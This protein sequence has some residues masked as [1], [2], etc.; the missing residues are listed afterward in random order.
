VA[1]S[2]QTAVVDVLVAKTLQAVESCGA[3]QVVL[4]G[5]VAANSKLQS[6]LG[7]ACSSRGIPLYF[8]SPLLCTDN[9]AMIGCR[10]YYKAQANKFA[11]LRLNALPSLKLGQ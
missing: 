9:A 1:A 5:G 7:D 4:A 3:R 10:A 6:M 8:P 11:D 2:F